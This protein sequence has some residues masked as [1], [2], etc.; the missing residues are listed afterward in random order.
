MG[1]LACRY[2]EIS[3]AISG[4]KGAMLTRQN[5][6]AIRNRERR[7]ERIARARQGKERPSDCRRMMSGAG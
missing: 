7:S 1:R 6:R 3:A 4:F 2:G 5:S